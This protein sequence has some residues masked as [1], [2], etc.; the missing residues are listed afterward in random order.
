M[1]KGDFVKVKAEIGGKLEAVH[2][3]VR[4]NGGSLE[5]DTDKKDGK[6]TVTVPAAPT[7]LNVF[8]T[9]KLVSVVL[10]V[11]ATYSLPSPGCRSPGIVFPLGWSCA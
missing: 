10:A 6:V 8:P 11:S 4:Q 1:A 9:S 5:I 2:V 3:E 7:L